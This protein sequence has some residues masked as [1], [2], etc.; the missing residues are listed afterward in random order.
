VK[1]YVVKQGD[2]LEKIA[3]A[4]GADPDAIWGDPKNADLKQ[5]RDPNLL[6]PGDVLYVPDPKKKWLELKASAD[7]LYVAKVPRT[8]VSLSFK[9]LNKPRA[10]APYVIHGMGEP[11]E[12]QTDGDGAIEVLVPV[13]VREIK[14]TFP[15]DYVTYAV[16]VGDMDPIDE[17]SGVRKRLQHMG[18]YDHDPGA[19]LEAADRRGI[20]AYQRARGLPQTSILDAATKAKLLADHGS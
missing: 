16:H 20:L 5:Q 12:G 19:D 10:N 15:K 17:P 9:D 14:V 8:K 2:Y 7:N 6:H 3:H 18:F 13:H 11:E 1:A 4:L